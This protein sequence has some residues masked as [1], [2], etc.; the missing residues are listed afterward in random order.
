MIS[1]IG[2]ERNLFLKLESKLGFYH[3]VLTTRK[4]SPEKLTLTIVEKQQLPDIKQTD[5]KK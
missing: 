4:T 5:S 2:D 3:V 1:N